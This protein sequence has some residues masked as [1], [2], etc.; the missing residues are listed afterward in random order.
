[1][2][3]SNKVILVGYVGQEMGLVELADGKKVLHFNLVTNEV[4]AFNN[5]RKEETIWH[6]ITAWDGIAETLAKH[7]KKGHLLGINGR[8]ATDSY[9]KMGV[10]IKTYTI[11]AEE[12]QLFEK[13]VD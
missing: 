5:E 11:V 1:M 4:Y 7:V 6:Q 2:S 8:I 12:I 13:K 9:E 10:K 3:F